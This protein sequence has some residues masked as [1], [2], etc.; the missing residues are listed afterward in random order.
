MLNETI[1]ERLGSE[2]SIGA[3]A[4]ATAR[5]TAAAAEGLAAFLEKREPK[6]FERL[7]AL[8]RERRDSIVQGAGDQGGPATAGR[9]LDRSASPRRHRRQ[10][11]PAG[12][13]VVAVPAQETGTGAVSLPTR[14]R[15]ST[16]MPRMPDR[17]RH[18]GDVLRRERNRAGPGRS[19]YRPCRS[20]LNRVRRGRAAITSARTAAPGSD[21]DSRHAVTA[22]KVDGE[23]PQRRGPPD[24]AA[25]GIDPE[26][27]AVSASRRRSSRRAHGRRWRRDRPGRA[28]HS[29]AGRLRDGFGRGR[30]RAGFRSGETRSVGPPPSDHK[31]RHQ[32][33]LPPEPSREGRRRE[34]LE[35]RTCSSTVG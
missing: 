12:G 34:W 8:N 31:P 9:Q 6:W 22:G 33:A 32:K 27:T 20:R 17:H 16:I 5:T 21:S 30:R 4:S 14:A 35:D 26:P 28:G 24:I 19:R 13:I 7:R 3:A 1:G 29:R 15:S 18:G 25:A 11:I 10:S 2:L 23:V